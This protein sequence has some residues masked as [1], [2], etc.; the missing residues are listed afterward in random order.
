MSSFSFIWV[1]AIVNVQI[2]QGVTATKKPA[3]MAA[4]YFEVRKI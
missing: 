3:V 4:K 1:N 2:V